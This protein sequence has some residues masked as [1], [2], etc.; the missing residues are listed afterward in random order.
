MDVHKEMAERIWNLNLRS[1]S[2]ISM[3]DLGG[4]GEK[5]LLVFVKGERVG[6]RVRE[7]MTLFRDSLPEDEDLCLEDS[8]KFSQSVCFTLF[9]GIL[10]PKLPFRFYLCMNTIKGFYRFSYLGNVQH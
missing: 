6:V 4:L 1:F 5:S 9:C 3:A 8:K 7:V 10:I 2:R